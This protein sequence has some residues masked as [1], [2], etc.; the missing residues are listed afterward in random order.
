M[1][2]FTVNVSLLLK[3]VYKK[4][5]KNKKILLTPTFWMVVYAKQ[6]FVQPAFV[7]FQSKK[8]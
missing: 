3:S 4:K 7:N 5:K 2:V 6:T 1:T 8:Q